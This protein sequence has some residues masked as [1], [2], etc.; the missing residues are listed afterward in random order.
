MSNVSLDYQITKGITHCTPAPQKAVI[1]MVEN[2]GIV[3]EGD[4]GK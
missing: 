1:I 4:G 2:A 3:P